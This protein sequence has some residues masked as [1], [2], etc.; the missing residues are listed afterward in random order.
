MREA[1]SSHCPTTLYDKAH[2][3]QAPKYS[4]PDTLRP[5][6]CRALRVAGCQANDVMQLACPLHLAAFHDRQD[7]AEVL[8]K[9]GAIVSAQTKVRMMPPQPPSTVVPDPCAD[10]SWSLTSQLLLQTVQDS[11]SF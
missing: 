3:G 11:L 10:A 1:T 9:N 5:S 7:A 4:R 8:L 6:D 2:H